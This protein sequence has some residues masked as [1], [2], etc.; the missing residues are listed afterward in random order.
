MLE[1]SHA[2]M[3]L[4]GRRKASAAQAGQSCIAR[5][6][7]HR[8]DNLIV[9]GASAGGHRVLAEIFKDFSVDMPAAIVLHQPTIKNDWS[10]GSFSF[11]RLANQQTIRCRPHD[12]G[13]RCP[14]DEDERTIATHPGTHAFLNKQIAS[15][16]HDLKAVEDLVEKAA[17]M[18]TFLARTRQAGH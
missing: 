14:V 10:K 3:Y 4:N 12:S 5:R 15:L 2:E 18:P 6:N 8:I 17:A 16:R 9:I 13:P 1:R 7:K 11:L